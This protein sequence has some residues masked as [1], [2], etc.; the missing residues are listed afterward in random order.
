MRKS[1][2]K[3]PNQYDSCQYPDWDL[4]CTFPNASGGWR[5]PRIDKL[6]SSALWD[7]REWFPTYATNQY[8]FMDHIISDHALEGLLTDP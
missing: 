2:H 4:L 3:T 6:K 5:Y 1:L 7:R 8:I